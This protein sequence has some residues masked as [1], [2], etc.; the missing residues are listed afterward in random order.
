MFGLTL[1]VGTHMPNMKLLAQAFQ[2]LYE[3]L[4]NGSGNIMK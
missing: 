2:T 3:K 1:A 4:E